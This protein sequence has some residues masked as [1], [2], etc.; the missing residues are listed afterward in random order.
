MLKYLGH[1]P[2]IAFELKPFQAGVSEKLIQQRTGHRS[3]EALCQYERT[4]PLQLLDASNT[5]AN[6]SK[7]DT[8]LDIY[9][10]PSCSPESVASPPTEQNQKQ[11]TIVFNGCTFTGCAVALSGPSTSYYKEKEEVNVAE[12]LQGITYGDIFDD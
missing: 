7:P 8:S 12:T 4:S 9:Q 6:V 10:K 11:P 5:M 2:I 1:T 3:I